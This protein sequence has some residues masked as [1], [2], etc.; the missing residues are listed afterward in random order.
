MI[1]MEKK[2][3][4][5]IIGIFLLINFYPFL[6]GLQHTPQG[7]V[8]LGAVHYP[9]DYLYYLNLIAQGKD[10]LIGQYQLT[11]EPM[12]PFFTYWIYIFLGRFG[13][14]FHISDIIMYQIGVAIFGAV[15]MFSAY[16]LLTKVFPHSPGKRIL[17]F[18]LFMFSNTFPRLI[19][20]NGV[21]SIHPYYSWYNYGEPFLRLSSVP[22]HLLIQASIMLFIY[23][24]CSW[25]PHS[26]AK[27]R[28]LYTA[29]SLFTGASL[30]SMNPIQFFL[31]T[32]TLGLISFLRESKHLLKFHIRY[33]V[34][35]EVPLLAFVVAG[36]PFVALAS[37]IMRSYIFSYASA[38]EAAQSPNMPWDQF[39]HYFGPVF[40]VSIVGIPML[41][42]KKNITFRTALWISLFGLFL[43]FLPFTKRIPVLTFRYLSALPVLVFAMGTTEGI[44][45]ISSL[46]R[47]A[48]PFIKS[49]AV[50][51][52]FVLL[53]PIFWTQLNTRLAY[54][55][56]N[57]L[58]YT[59]NEQM[60]VFKKAREISKPD[61]GFLVYW[62]F[63][64]VFPSIAARR[65]Y[66]IRAN[67]T[68]GT[69]EKSAT[70]LSFLTNK[71]SQEEKIQFLK[72]NDIKFIVAYNDAFDKEF[73]MVKRIYNGPTIG[74]FKVSL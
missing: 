4:S 20:E 36:A 56:A 50:T 7:S 16:L 54:D 73:P 63:D 65:Q 19:V 15:F 8:F 37:L 70:A 28:G 59:T 68:P 18:L 26:T 17:G 45:G 47:S 29:L 62:P 74:I 32:G 44:D 3:I 11:L 2:I 14:I 51:L 30:G 69:A 52:L 22:H 35:N 71:M 13:S 25:N 24:F 55:P 9:V 66:L 72:Q 67:T 39:V 49:M 5:C 43:F 46:F 31:L 64:Q 41:L 40:V 58:L 33:I 34:S 60:D 53:V 12:P 23:V 57:P 21:K 38:W 6:Y 10:R 27:K 48:A 1:L 42:R 61:D